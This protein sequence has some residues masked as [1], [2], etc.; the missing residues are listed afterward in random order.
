MARDP[1][2]VLKELAEATRNRNLPAVRKLSAELN[3]S[4]ENSPACDP[5]LFVTQLTEAVDCFDRPRVGKLCDGFVNGLGE[6]AG[7]CR[8]SEA[9]KVLGIL[10]RKRY[11]D[12]MVRVAEAL[13]EDGQDAPGV[14]R[15]SCGTWWGHT[16]CWV[17][18]RTWI[19]QTP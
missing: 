15:A 5:G 1:E 19:G 4:V 14:R 17:T 12:E 7:P 8:L 13:M 3:R 6:K 9:T 10:R 2:I 11:F 18:K 16:K